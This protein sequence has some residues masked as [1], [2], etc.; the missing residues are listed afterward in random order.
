MH[1]LCTD[2]VKFYS[3]TVFSKKSDNKIAV[4]LPVTPFRKQTSIW[5]LMSLV[6]LPVIGDEHCLMLVSDSY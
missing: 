3:G 4:L 2:D 5:K 1:P 6:H